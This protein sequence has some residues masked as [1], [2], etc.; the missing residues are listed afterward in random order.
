MN[1][2]SRVPFDG[3]ARARSARLV[4]AIT[5]ALGVAILGPAS[6]VAA[7]SQSILSAGPLT[8]VQ[9]SD[10]LNCAVDHTGDTSPEFFG[11]TA[12]GTLVAVGG[13]LYGPAYIPAG[14]SAAP[15][16]TF[17]AI[18]QS[19]VTGSGSNADPY[20]IVTVVGL[21]ATGLRITETDTY[22]VG[23]E[24]YRT[25]V[26]VSN[27]G[28]S[29]LTAILYR[30]GDCY[31]QNSDYGFGANDAATGS[32]SCVAGMPD[33][34]GGTVRGTRIEQWYPLSSGSSFTE[35]DF[36]SVWAQIGTQTAFPNACSQCASYIDNGAGLS[37]NLSVPAGGSVTRS[38]LTVFSPLGIVPLS[39]SKTAAAPSAAAGAADSY[40]ITVSNSNTQAATLD[41]ISDS[42]PAGFTYTAGS[43]S[44]A[45]TTDPAISG[46]NLT[47]TGP[48]TVPASGSLALTF[49][50]TVSTTPGT[51]E[52]SANAVAQSPFVVV[53]TGPTAPVTVGGPPPA[54]AQ[55]TLVKNI[56][57][58]GGGTALATDWTL[59]ATGPTTVSGHTGDAAITNAAVT[60]GKYRLSE[61][62]P[63]G[64][65]ASAWSCTA[66]TLSGNRLTLASGETASCTITNTFV[67]ATSGS[68][69]SILLDRSGSMNDHR[70]RTIANFNS[71]LA[72]EQQSMLDA[73]AT[74]ALFNACGY[75]QRGPTGRVIARVPDLTVANYH[76]RCNTPLYDAI[77]KT[78]NRAAMDPL[79]AGND[80]VIVVYTDGQDNASKR[81]TQHQVDA[82]IANKTALGWTFVWL[83]NSVDPLIVKWS[84]QP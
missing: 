63:S 5:A 83:G 1:R 25:D 78:I 64:Y 43:S 12:C 66:G 18:S 53:G 51:Y 55:L 69:V 54:G 8:R 10:D 20:K 31:L 35:N 70:T 44:G 28:T 59:T 9:I 71:W 19:A 37:W 61:S 13:T 26:M 82:L 46:Q 41:S 57:N 29:A 17:T 22:V 67:T 58:T 15:R 48:F 16:T 75:V 24:T 65:T 6:P 21:G 80:V 2:H 76:G 52:N 42:L 74:L 77:A 14:G 33:G 7:A 79:A 45:T 73:H 38:H 49:G 4:V 50:V 32:V 3:W 40:T 27:S 72:A 34:S 36:N 11:D 60:P 47:W 84:T 62:G 56:D 68:Y 23:Q 81:W 30:A 39:M